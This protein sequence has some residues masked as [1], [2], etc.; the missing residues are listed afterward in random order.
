MLSALLFAVAVGVCLVSIH[1]AYP[2]DFAFPPDPISC[3]YPPEPVAPP[4]PV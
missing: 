4:L 2:F 3:T 1:A